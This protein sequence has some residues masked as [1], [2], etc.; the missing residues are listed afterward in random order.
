MTFLEFEGFSAQN[1]RNRVLAFLSHLI[2]RKVE[3]KKW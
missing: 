1:K 3:V 2:L